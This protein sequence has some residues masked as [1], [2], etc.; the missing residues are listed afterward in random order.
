M[1]V[2]YDS[3]GGNT[4]VDSGNTSITTASWTHTPV[5]TLNAVW[6]GVEMG[7]DTGDVV[8]IVAGMT[9]T[10]G[11][12]T[13]TAYPG[14]LPSITSATARAKVF[15]RLASDAGGIPS[16]AQ[17]AALA[18]GS[19]NH[20]VVIG[21]SIG[22][23]GTAIGVRTPA[24][25]TPNA[26]SSDAGTSISSTI[27]S[28]TG[29]LVLMFLCHG[30]SFGASASLQSGGTQRKLNNVDTDTA[31]NNG[32]SATWPGAATVAVGVTTSS[33]DDSFLGMALSFQETGG[34]GAG[35]VAPSGLI[36]PGSSAVRRAS[37]V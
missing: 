19:T 17:T 15:Y 7:Q 33:G 11:G 24:G 14:T 25:T 36:I 26:F 31:G 27:T 18:F 12:Q 20:V 10:Y 28:A 9:A 4:P 3:A 29:E 37:F 2:A 5:G 32:V 21:H 13:M 1:T 8:A 35:S 22:L 6:F 34:G 30:A 23:T 16:G